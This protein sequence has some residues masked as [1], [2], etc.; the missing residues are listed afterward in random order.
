MGSSSR[1]NREDQHKA[2]LNYSGRAIDCLW[3]VVRIL[4]LFVGTLE[5]HLRFLARPH[6]RRS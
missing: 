5:A 1:L 3:L 2:S 4:S 6:Q